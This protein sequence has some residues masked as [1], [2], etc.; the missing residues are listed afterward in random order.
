MP[1][2]GRLVYDPVGKY[3]GA[4]LFFAI[5]VTLFVPDFGI[6]CALLFGLFGLTI[7]SMAS[8][9]VFLITLWHETTVRS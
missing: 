2:S 5:G 1:K 7:V 3:Y 4:Y 6:C 9:S 8:R